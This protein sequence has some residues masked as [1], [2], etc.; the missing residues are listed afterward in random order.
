VNS[1]GLMS[2]AWATFNTLQLITSLPLLQLDMPENVLTFQK[3]F[4]KIVNLEV[5]PK[6]TVL[7]YLFGEEY[8]NLIDETEGLNA[9]YALELAG[10]D[11]EN[12]LKN[13]SMLALAISV[14]LIVILLLVV[15]RRP[16]EA[17]AHPTCKK[18]C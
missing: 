6:E 2:K 12:T 18:G 13:V 15:C 14:A 3:E 16:I 10:I 1:K 8:T 11:K 9:D 17:K 7:Y 4:E 5:I